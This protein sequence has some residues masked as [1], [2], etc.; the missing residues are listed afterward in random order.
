MRRGSF[1]PVWCGLLLAAAR[2]LATPTLIPIP[3]IVSTGAGL[4]QGASD[5][6]FLLISAPAG[7]P[8]TIFDSDGVPILPINPVVVCS[9]VGCDGSS[10]PA[11]PFWAGAWV[12]NNAN[13]QW[14]GVNAVQ[15]GDISATAGPGTGVTTGDS[16]GYYVFEVEFYLPSTYAASTAVISG[17]W[18]ADNQGTMYLNG[19]PITGCEYPTCFLE[20][21]TFDITTGFVVGVN[22]VQIVVYNLPQPV[23]NPVGF[24]ID[25]TGTYMTPEPG[26]AGLWLAGLAALGLL[27]RR[28]RTS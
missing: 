18:S 19:I 7:V 9:T 27:R 14:V 12:A 4:S 24:R 20:M 1:I 8:V 25:W 21:H 22:Y 16:A 10:I 5:V 15:Y 6:N 2:A 11:F 23:G 13:S 17:F 3:G 26:T 28:R